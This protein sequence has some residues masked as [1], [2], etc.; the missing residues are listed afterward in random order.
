MKNEHLC[1]LRYSQLEDK[2]DYRGSSFNVPT[3]LLQLVGN[4]KDIHIAKI[5]PN[6]VRGNHYHLERKEIII[7]FYD[8]IWM[9]GWD[10]GYNTTV[11]QAKFSGSGTLLIEV[12]SNISHA[13]KN[14]G[15]KDLLIIALSSHIYG[16][17]KSDTFTRIVL[18]SE[19]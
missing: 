14:I 5:L 7:V 3:S 17:E 13:I 10:N 1:R 18:P 6:Y 15:R 4:I 8:D 9:L 16:P 19:P 11:M 12:E 2:G